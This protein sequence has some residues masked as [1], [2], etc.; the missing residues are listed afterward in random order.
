MLDSEIEPYASELEVIKT[1]FRNKETMVE[2]MKQQVEFLS[3][4]VAKAK[5][6]NSLLSVMS[7][8]TTGVAAAVSL[9]YVARRPIMLIDLYQ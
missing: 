3:D 6:K 8:A 9:A 1:A 5:K 4:S 2:D 7:S